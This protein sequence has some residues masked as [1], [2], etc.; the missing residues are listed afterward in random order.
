[1]VSLVFWDILQLPHTI[2]SN[3][4]KLTHPTVQGQDTNRWLA[5]YAVIAT[6]CISWT[7]CYHVLNFPSV[8]R[9]VQEG[10]GGYSA[11]CGS[12]GVVCGGG[13]AKC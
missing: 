11:K 7:R 12:V 4:E 1:M 8:S 9:I 10:G 2:I 3:S 5:V 6:N 13:A